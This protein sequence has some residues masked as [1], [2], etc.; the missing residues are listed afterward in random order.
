MG[1]RLQSVGTLT[2]SCDFLHREVLRLVQR[3]RD[4]GP[5]KRF[6]E[7]RRKQS[8]SYAP[9]QRC[10]FLW[11]VSGAPLPAVDLNTEK[12]F[13]TVPHFWDAVLS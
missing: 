9:E 12:G 1:A 10:C 13:P 11:L 5:E 7:S 2:D 6:T 3:E 8:Q 4:C